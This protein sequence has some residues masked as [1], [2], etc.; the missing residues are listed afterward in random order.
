MHIAF[1]DWKSLKSNDKNNTCKTVCKIQCLKYGL[2][3][4][5]S[6]VA[7]SSINSIHID[8]FWPHNSWRGAGVKL[9]PWHLLLDKELVFI[10]LKFGT[11]TK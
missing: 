11:N 5:E 2:Q 8:V 1:T 7:V 6:E 3:F 10:E 4:N 9:S